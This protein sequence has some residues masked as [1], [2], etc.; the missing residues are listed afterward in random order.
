MPKVECGLWSLFKTPASRVSGLA[1][2]VGF[3]VTSLWSIPKLYL[4]TFPS[5]DGNLTAPLAISRLPRPSTPPIRR[6]P[7]LSRSPAR[8]ILRSRP[9]VFIERL[10]PRCGLE[11]DYPTPRPP[12]FTFVTPHQ[13]AE[14]S[15]AAMQ[16]DSSS[17]DPLVSVRIRHR[18]RS[19]ESPPDA[20]K[21]NGPQLLVNDR[22][23]YK[24]MLIR[25]YSSIWMIGGFVFIVYMGHL[26]I[27]AMIVVIQIFMAR[28]LFNLLRKANED[29]QLPGFRLLNWHFFFTAMIYTY[30]RFLSRQLVNTITSDKLLYQLVS[31]LIKY[32]MF[33]CYFL[34]IAGF[35]WFILTL[36]KKMYKY[37]FRQYAWTHMIL[38]LVFAQSSFTVANIY[39]GI[40][41]FLLP[42]S[43]IVINDI[44]AYFFGFFF[45]RT[46]LIKLS[47]KKTWEGFIGAS[48]TTIFSAFVLA[49]VLGRFQ[50]LTCPRK[51]LST[52]WL[53]CDPGPMFKPEYYSLP[54]WVP[55]SFPWKDV[56]I[57]P[58][59][60]HAIALGLFASI[61]A[62]FGGFFA[63]GF[64]RAFNFKD[65]G[66][67][68]PGHGG[69]TDRMDCQMVM[70]VFAYIYHQSFVMPQSLSVEMIL[71]Q[72]LRNLT[73]NEQRVLYEELGKI[74]HER[75]QM[76][77]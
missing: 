19:T 76:Q 1:D 14:T 77:Y 74:F 75:Q 30:G 24:S 18:K 41:W 31:G 47:P 69:I 38:L 59:Q 42:A 22:N 34:Y 12:Q 35:V 25:T 50:W 32:Q 63:S 7:L 56:P 53:Y 10:H 5:R 8:S 44:A 66:D 51:D 23:K 4:A 48:I 58:V 40:F 57:M 15:A 3:C 43:L 49:N 62:P 6:V 73:F 29:R 13:R 9:L 26:Y 68:I 67:S 65:F 54:G 45:G 39:E 55:Q 11:M 27:W 71:E 16:K 2:I 20:T 17:S 70:A 33:I 28:E 36:K 46:P 52:G 60:W 72:I 21:P 37:Q 61:I 64:K